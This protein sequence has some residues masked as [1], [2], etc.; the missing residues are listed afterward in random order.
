M[1]IEGH[2]KLGKPVV[3]EL[4]RAVIYDDFDNPV[5][6]AIKHRDGFMYVGHIRDPE[7]EEYLKCLGLDKSVIVN[8]IDPNKINAKK[9]NKS[10]LRSL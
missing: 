2:D 1:R 9:I 3:L 7:F 4:T 6:C 8:V 10:M 5:A